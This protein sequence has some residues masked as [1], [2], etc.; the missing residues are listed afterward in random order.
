MKR[1]PVVVLQQTANG[2]KAV[3]ASVPPRGAPRSER[4]PRPP[5]HRRAVGV[6]DSASLAL[7]ERYHVVEL[8]ETAGQITQLAGEVSKRIGKGPTV[9][10]GLF[11]LS[12]TK[13]KG[14]RK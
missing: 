13:K 11:L 7:D 12:K 4:V 10:L 14:K 6:E 9:L 8:L 1:K 3:R 2:W 5:E